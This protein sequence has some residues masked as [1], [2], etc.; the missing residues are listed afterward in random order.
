MKRIIVA[1]C[2]FVACLVPAFSYALT[3]PAASCPNLT[4]DMWVGSCDQSL[5]DSDC[6]RR[7]TGDQVSELQRFLMRHLNNPQGLWVSGYFGGRTRQYVQQFQREWDVPATGYVGTLTRRAIA[8]ACKGGDTTVNQMRFEASP[9]RGNAPLT[10]TFSSW[11]SGFRAPNISYKID[12]GDGTSEAAANCSAPADFCISPGT[13]THTYTSNGT[14]TALLKKVTG[15][16]CV[17]TTTTSC[18]AWES[19]EEVVARAQVSVGPV[20]CTLEY[21]PVCGSKQVTCITTPCNPVQQTYSNRCMMNADGATFVHAGECRSTPSHPKDDPQCKR[22]REAGF[23]SGICFRELPGGAPMCAIPL[24]SPVDSTS[25]PPNPP[26]QCLEYFTNTGNRPP[27]IS[28]FSG[29]TTL[30][31]NQTGTWTVSASDPENGQLTYQVKWGDEGWFAG[32]LLDS[33]F[34]ASDFIQTTTFTHSYVGAGTYTIA[35]IARDSAGNVART[36]TTVR[37]TG[38]ETPACTSSVYAP[39]CGQPPFVCNAPEGAACAQVMPQP[40]TYANRCVMNSAGATFLYEGVCKS[41]FLGCVSGGVTYP[42]GHKTNTVTHANGTVSSIADAY[43]I[44]R[45]GEWKVEGGIIVCAQDMMQCPNGE[46]V[47]RT[48]PNCAFVCPGSNSGNKLCTYNG[49][50]YE[51]G[52][53]VCMAPEGQDGFQTMMCSPKICRNGTWVD[54]PAPGGTTWTTCPSGQVLYNGTCYPA[55][56]T[57]GGSVAGSSGTTDPANMPFYCKRWQTHTCSGYTKAATWSEP[58]PYNGTCAPNERFET[59]RCTEWF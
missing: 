37:V 22:W 7:T 42:E 46:W 18:A 41:P 47:G 52:G 29:P 23:C 12:F 3:Q 14:Y 10:V 58:A 31:V 4:E 13:N 36:T 33:A 34:G 19:M 32:L 50:S 17:G 20:A 16:T 44:C 35:V 54:D 55:E 51:T 43:Y 53:K 15:H 21:A 59:P 6:E 25:P 2:L 39:V 24:C 38:G 28:S 9:L 27:V 26:A 40:Q 11:I 57:T 5:S 8:E 1:S 49:T 45:S 56:T 30:N 48:G